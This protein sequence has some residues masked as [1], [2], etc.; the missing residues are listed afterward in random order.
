MKVLVDPEPKA[1]P[2]FTRQ[3]RAYTPKG[4]RDYEALLKDAFNR[5][6]GL[7][8]LENIPLRCEVVFHVKRPKVKRDYPI[9]R[10]DVDNL[11]KAVL[12]AMNGTVVKDDG[13]FCDVEAKKRYADFEPFLEVTILRLDSIYR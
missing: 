10:P 6:W 4:T 7:P 2:R 1:R 8:V 5:A 13:L 9:T 11:L 12:D 3:G